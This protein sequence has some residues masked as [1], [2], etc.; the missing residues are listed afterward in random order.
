MSSSILFFC[1]LL[2]DSNNFK[3][4]Q[5]QILLD[6][7]RSFLCGMF[8]GEYITLFFKAI[9]ISCSIK[10]GIIQDITTKSETSSGGYVPE[11]FSPNLKWWETVG[12][13]TYVHKF[14]YE[15]FDTNSE[16]WLENYNIINFDMINN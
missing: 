5:H 1:K 10:A 9:S 15:E 8:I 16:K 6:F 14:K 12:L 13:L 4:I 2:V 11:Y 7:L 3:V